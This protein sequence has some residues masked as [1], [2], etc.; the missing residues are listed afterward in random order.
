[1]DPRA[2]GPSDIDPSDIDP[3][4]IEFGDTGFD[5]TGFGDIGSCNFRSGDIDQPSQLLNALKLVVRDLSE[6]LAQTYLPPEAHAT[7]CSG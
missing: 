6:Q 5:D 7:V 1:M 3:S 4:D 2:I